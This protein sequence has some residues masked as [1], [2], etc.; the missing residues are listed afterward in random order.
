MLYTRRAGREAEWKRGTVALLLGRE[1]CG[2]NSE[3]LAICDMVVSIPTSGEYP[4]M[5]L[6]HAAAILFYE[7]SGSVSGATEMASRQS[8]NLLQEGA[9]SLLREVCYPEHKADFADLMLRRIFGRTELTER[10]ARSLL[11]IIKRIRWRITHGQEHGM[12]AEDNA[13]G[14]T[15]KR[16]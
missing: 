12:G 1:D 4:V 10:E 16:L 3:E 13:L 15:L 14:A 11:G 7:L 8:L 2:L 5:N 9:N 6:S